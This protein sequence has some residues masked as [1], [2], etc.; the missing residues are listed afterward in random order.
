MPRSNPPN[1]QVALTV[2][3]RAKLIRKATPNG[4][5]LENLFEMQNR[6][7]DLCGHPIQDLICAELDHSTSVIFFARSDMPIEDAIAKAND[8]KNLRCAHASCNAAKNGLTREEWFARGLNERDKPQLLTD[9]QLLELQFRL[10][11]GGRK[12]VESGHLAKLR[13]PEHQ[14]NAARSA[15]KLHP[16]LARDNGRVGGRIGGVKGAATAMRN[17]TGIFG[18]S[19]EQRLEDCRKGGQRNIESGHI[20]SLGRKAVASGRLASYRTHEHQVA[21]GLAASAKRGH[22]AFVIQGRNA[23]H[24]RWH[25]NRGITNQN[26]ELCVLPMAADPKLLQKRLD[27]IRRTYYKTRYKIYKN[28]RSFRTAA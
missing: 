12:H 26:C 28:H 6:I 3:Q 14:R 25:V 24:I 8:P 17:K 1:P 16:T 2:R 13:T 15:H 19:P 20:A 11:A 23:M 21:A 27:K 4:D 18:R 10:G 9:G 22:L 5:T 7:C